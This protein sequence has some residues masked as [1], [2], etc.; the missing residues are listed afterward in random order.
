[1]R[2]GHNRGMDTPEMRQFEQAAGVTGG[3]GGAAAG[4]W[5]QVFCGDCL[6]IAGVLPR[7]C[8]D[9]ACWIRHFSQIGNIWGM[10]RGR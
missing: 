5:G 9:L 2:C 4:P 10:G 3:R 6:G 8:V 7:G 1:M